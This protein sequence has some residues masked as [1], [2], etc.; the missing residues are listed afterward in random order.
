MGEAVGE[1]RRGV[2]QKDYG[3]CDLISYEEAAKEPEKYRVA[4]GIAGPGALIP[5]S[6]CLIDDRER[7][8]DIERVR[9]L[10]RLG[11]IDDQA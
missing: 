2:E 5:R 10:V 7:E 6:A 11:L 4:L 3:R 8:A 1:G 9:E